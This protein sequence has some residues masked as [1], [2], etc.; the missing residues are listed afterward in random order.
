[1]Y[2]SHGVYVW[3]SMCVVLRYGNIVTCIWTTVLSL[4]L[5]GNV[6]VCVA[7]PLFHSVSTLRASTT[8]L[9]TCLCFL[10]VRMAQQMGT[11]GPETGTGRSIQSSSSRS[12]GSMRCLF[13]EVLKVR[14]GVLTGVA[15]TTL[16]VCPSI[17]REIQAQF[18]DR[19]P[20]RL[21]NCRALTIHPPL[22]SR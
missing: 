10:H 4:S 7:N 3:L 21:Q 9:A 12:V 22:D 5:E 6:R 1:V 15:V 18:E 17:L 14:T 16:R 8:T 19:A 11:G 2:Y 20:E 13:A